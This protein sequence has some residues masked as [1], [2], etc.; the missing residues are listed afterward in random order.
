[1]FINLDETEA[2]TFNIVIKGNIHSPE[3]AFMT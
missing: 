3:L 1:M 2:H